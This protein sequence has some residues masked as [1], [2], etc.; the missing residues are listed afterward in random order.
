MLH[1][2]S[3]HVYPV[4]SCGGFSPPEWDVDHF[5][6]RHDRRWM[7]VDLPVSSSLK[8]KNRDSR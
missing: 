6:L 4:K 8:G 1:L 5:G 2:A 3:L 7:V